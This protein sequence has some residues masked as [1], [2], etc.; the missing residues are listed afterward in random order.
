MACMP[1]PAQLKHTTESKLLQRQGRATG[2]DHRAGS[3]GVS[4]STSKEAC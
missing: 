4:H 3:E 2:G 1:S